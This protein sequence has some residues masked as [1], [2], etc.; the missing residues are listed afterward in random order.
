MGNTSPAQPA[1]AQNYFAQFVRAPEQAPTTPAPNG[2]PNVFSQFVPPQ[3]A[4]PGPWTKYAPP[5]P[6][7]AGYQLVPVDDNPWEKYRPA[8]S[9]PSAVPS[10]QGSGVPAPP[11]GYKLVP[12]DHD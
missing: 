8:D 3:S 6:P 1:S 4:E 12:V 11:P 10:G 5:A 7:P 9:D 2:S